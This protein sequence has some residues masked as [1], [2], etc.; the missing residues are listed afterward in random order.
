METIEIKNSSAIAKIVFNDE[1]NI[2]GICFTSNVEKSYDFYCETFED[3]KT[4]IIETD[5][6]G[7]SVGKLIHSYRKDG[8][9][10]VI[11]DE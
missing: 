7:E 4:K 6:L 1:K 5:T 9:L 8:T 10:E 2:V 11:V 3:T